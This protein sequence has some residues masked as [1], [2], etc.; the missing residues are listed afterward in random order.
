MKFKFSVFNLIIGVAFI[1]AFVCILLSYLTQYM[2]YPAMAFF[3]GAFVM[4]SIR[5][6][7]N[8]IKQNHITAEKQDAIIMELAMEEDGEK[9]VMQNE[10]KQKNIA[11]QH[12]RQN[13]ERL[14]PFAMSVLC[15]GLFI[16]LFVSSI[17]SLF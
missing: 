8:Y 1:L 3:A 6:M 17:V 7:Q 4:L 16:Y 5:I 12:R 2:Y 11:K 15:A 9:Y 10:K 13:I 14:L